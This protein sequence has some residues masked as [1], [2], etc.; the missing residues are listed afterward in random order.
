MNPPGKSLIK[1]DFKKAMCLALSSSRLKKGLEGQLGELRQTRDR[2]GS[3]CCP[4]QILTERDP[5]SMHQYRVVSFLPFLIADLRYTL[6]IHL[7]FVPS[8]K[9]INGKKW[10]MYSLTVL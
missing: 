5:F 10:Q 2:S 3:P 9:K 4:I 6:E 7:P 1:Y 8:C